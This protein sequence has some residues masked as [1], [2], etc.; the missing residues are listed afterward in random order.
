[1]YKRQLSC[2]GQPDEPDGP[3]TDPEPNPDFPLGDRFSAPYE[4]PLPAGTYNVVEGP[5]SCGVSFERYVNGAW[6]TSR[7]TTTGATGF[8]VS[9]PI[10]DVRLI[11]DSPPCLYERV[12]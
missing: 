12:A 11:G 7:T 10:R 4:P 5:G 3:V 9:T 6:E 1:M 8:E 2:K